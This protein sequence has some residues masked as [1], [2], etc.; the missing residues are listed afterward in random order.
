[1]G[2]LRRLSEAID[3]FA[4]AVPARDPGEELDAPPGAA[5]AAELPLQ[6]LPAHILFARFWEARRA[7]YLARRLR[8]DCP[9][10][11]APPASTWFE[12]QDGYRY[13]I[14]AAC[15]MVF[16][17]EFLP[18]A[19]WD[20]YYAA[21]P[22]ARDHLRRQ[23][24][25]SVSD[26]ATARDRDRFGRYLSVL[27]EHGAQLAGAR[28]LDIGSFT[29]ASLRVAADH[30]IVARGVEALAEAVEFS[31]SRFPEV[32]LDHVV[33]ERMDPALFGD[34]FD[35][36]TLWETLEHTV[37]P[38][39][40]L[41]LAA[42]LMKPGA[43]IALTVPNARNVQFSVLREFCFFAYGG[44]HGIGH[45]NMFSPDSLKGA[46]KAA[47]LEL[48]HLS[49]EFGT[50]W[51]QLVYYLQQRFERIHCY[52][53][54]VERGDA[55][56]SPGPELDVVLNWLSPALTRAENACAAGPIMLALAR[57]TGEAGA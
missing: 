3:A 53:T 8:R 55:V 23:L 25:A 50:D 42:G 37:D 56:D 6:N 38:V 28:L 48:V 2:A 15:R 29:G 40:S 54:L 10:C 39:R 19:A 9:V 14:C 49:T 22:D 43:W 4:A 57:R 51:R 44:Y 32:H 5:G 20:E 41:G 46:L 45:I 31:R 11:G 1:M 21:I 27:R 7:T 12:T 17:P 24:E 36:V 33:A 35:I 18:P 30:G 13:A 47:G 52:R 26:E 34:P 16:I